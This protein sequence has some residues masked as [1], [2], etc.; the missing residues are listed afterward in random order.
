MGGCTEHHAI[1]CDGNFI[2]AQDATACI[3]DLKKLLNI[4]VTGYATSSSSCDGGT[5]G[6]MAAAGG[7]ASASCAVSPRGEPALPG[8]LFFLGAGMTA[9]GLARRRRGR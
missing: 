2:N 7:T 3:D 4:Q 8:S 6:A 9:L 5:C 1:F